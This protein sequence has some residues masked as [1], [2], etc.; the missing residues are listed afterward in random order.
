MSEVTTEE[1]AAMAVILDDKVR[2]LV[3][4]HLREALEDPSFV[5]SLAAWNLTD[6]VCRHASTHSGF[7]AAVIQLLTQ[8]LNH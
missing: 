2:E 8:K 1:Q 4:K 5:S 7:R 6:V 3:R